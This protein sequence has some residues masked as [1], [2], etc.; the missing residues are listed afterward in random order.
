ME[1][2]AKLKNDVSDWMNIMADRAEWMD[3]RS[4]NIDKCEQIYIYQQK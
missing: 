3:R 1:D 2:L 4:D